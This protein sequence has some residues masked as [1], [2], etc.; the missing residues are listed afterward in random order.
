MT[1]LTPPETLAGDLRRLTA[2]E[3]S[4]PSRLRYIALLLV[5]AALSSVVIALLVTEPTLPGR[6]SIALG[7]LAIIGV[8]W[9]I[10]A[11]WVLTHKRVLLAGHRVVAGRLAVAFCTVFVVGALAVGVTT[12]RVSPFAAAALGAVML[13]VA[14]AVLIRAQ[15][16]FERLSARRDELERLAAGR[17]R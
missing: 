9:T 8:S 5:A 4:L 17:N 12:L 3:L 13:A 6:T 1:H 10:F 7:V 2:L 11:S 14:V 15:R 16:R